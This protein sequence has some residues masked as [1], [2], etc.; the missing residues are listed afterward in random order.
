MVG[1]VTRTGI[2]DLKPGSFVIIDDAPCRVEKVQVSTSGKH[3]AAKVR[4][5]AIGLLDDK[6]RSMVAPSHEEVSVPIILKKR[7]QVLALV[8][9]KAQLM[10]LTTYETFEL[11]IPEDV[12][13]K[14]IA[15]GEISYFEVMG[16]RTLKQLK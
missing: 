5:E 10:D 7:A 14:I 4:I 12:K 1:E 2:K 6:R 16:I 13:D 9:N 3:G 15:G 11:D 8:G